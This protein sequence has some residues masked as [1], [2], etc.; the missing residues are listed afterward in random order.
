MDVMLIVEERSEGE[1][2]EILKSRSSRE[3]AIPTELLNALAEQMGLL[4]N[5]AE[6]NCGSGKLLEFVLSCF[7]RWVVKERKTSVLL[8]VWQS[9]D[10]I[11]QLVKSASISSSVARGERVRELGLMLLVQ[12]MCKFP[13]AVDLLVHSCDLLQLVERLWVC[14]DFN[15]CLIA[16]SALVVR[17]FAV[18]AQSVE[19]LERVL[20]DD[21]DDDDD[22]SV[23]MAGNEEEEGEAE[24]G[25]E[26]GATRCAQ[27]S[28]WLRR[29][30]HG[31]RTVAV[32]EVGV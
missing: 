21:V 9:G 27:P 7:Y 18:S 14:A 24:E 4:I 1:E 8:S 6:S 16:L 25:N 19:V 29:A 32:V 31:P 15:K 23:Q 22:G 2:E 30:L 5:Q 26:D 3:L 10:F 12:L 13:T 11:R 20:K 17:R 28:K